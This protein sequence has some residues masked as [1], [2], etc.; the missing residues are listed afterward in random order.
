[1][2]DLDAFASHGTGMTV[3][4]GACLFRPG[5]RSEAF[6][7]LR[8]G[9]VRVEQTNPE[10]RTVVLYRIHAGDSCVM[11]TSCLLGDQPYA[12]YGYAEGE[13]EALAISAATFQILL[14]ENPSF[15][16]MVFGAFA[17]RVGELSEVIAALLLHRTDTRLATWLSGWRDRPCVMTQQ[18]IAQEIGTAREVVSRTLKSFEREGWLTLG[19]GRLEVIDPDALAAY[20]KGRSM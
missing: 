19:R 10:G 8:R 14:A 18:D 2:T 11:T 16:A 1:M 20:G 15:R 13:V 5:D 12:G 6:L 4:D 3:P 17:R 7:I 9:Q